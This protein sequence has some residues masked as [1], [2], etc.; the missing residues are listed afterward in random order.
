MREFRS[1]FNEI[2]V[3]SNKFIIIL[4]FLAFIEFESQT[5]ERFKFLTI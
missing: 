1:S 5:M 4:I 3:K 2:Y